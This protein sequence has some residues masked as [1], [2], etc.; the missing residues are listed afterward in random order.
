MSQ[1]GR[2]TYTWTHKCWNGT[3]HSFLFKAHGHLRCMDWSHSHKHTLQWWMHLRVD[4]WV[5]FFHSYWNFQSTLYRMWF[6]YAF[7]GNSETCTKIMN[8]SCIHLPRQ[9]SRLFGTCLAVSLDMYLSSIQWSS[10][11]YFVFLKTSNL[12]A[13]QIKI[14]SADDQLRSCDF[15]LFCLISTHIWAKLRACSG[16]AHPDSNQDTGTVFPLIMKFNQ[17][18]NNFFFF[19]HSFFYC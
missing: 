12:E 7:N 15:L 16:R 17:S 9:L 2:H 8:M 4:V 5:F 10:P 13:F 14:N 1:P 11:C 18:G 19:L 6:Y 3:S